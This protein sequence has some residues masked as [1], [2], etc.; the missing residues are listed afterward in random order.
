MGYMKANKKYILEEDEGVSAVIG[1]IL[2]VAITVAI[3][4]TVYVYVSGMMGTGGE[5][6]PTMIWTINEAS[7]KLELTKTDPNVAWEDL[8]FRASQ[9]V[10]ILANG[11]ATALDG[12]AIGANALTT[13]ADAHMAGGDASVSAQASDFINIQGPAGGGQLQNVEIRIIHKDSGS[14]IGTYTFVTLAEAV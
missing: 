11:D 7:D 8:Q 1:V 13:F 10:L 12:Q 3:A 6:A 4:A 2:M 5:Q 9:D 14:V